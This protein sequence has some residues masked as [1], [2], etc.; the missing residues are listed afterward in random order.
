MSSERLRRLDMAKGIAWFFVGALAMV[1]LFRFTRG[2]GPTTALTDLTPWGFWI[3]FD[4][5]GGVALAAGGFVITATVY[6]FHLENYHAIVRPAVLTA[7]LG[8]IA[9]VIGLLFDLGLPWNIWHMILFWNPHSPLFEVGWCVM[10]YSTV[11]ALEFAPVVLESAKHPVLMKV[12]TFVKKG[13][14]VFVILGIAF[15]TLHQSSLGSLFLIMPHRLDPLWYTPILPILF[16]ISAVG[17]GLSMI[18]TES[19]I[20]SWLYEKKPETHLLAGLAKAASIVL[21]LFVIV[22]FGDLIYR[23]QIGR[24]FT[25]SFNTVLFWIEISMM[26]FIPIIAM[27]IPSIRNRARILRWVAGL[28]VTGIVLNRVDIGGLAMIETTGTRYV[29]AWTEF[30]VSIGIVALAVLVF[31]FVVERFSVMEAGPMCTRAGCGERPKLLGMPRTVA[32]AVIGAGLAAALM[33]TSAID[34]YPVVA[35]PVRAPAFDDQMVIDG[36]RN[37]KGVR[38]DHKMHAEDIV[39]EDQGGCAGCHHMVRMGE[40]VTACDECHRDMEMPTNIF[41][42]ELH[43]DMLRDTDKGCRACHLDTK[44]P[45]ERQ[46]TT[47]CMECHKGMVPEGSSYP[48]KNPPYFGDAPSY[49]DAMHT[50]CKGCHDKMD[51]E[52]EEEVPTLGLCRTCHGEEGIEF[53][54]FNPDRT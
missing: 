49:E 53:D 31:F 20:T 2:L 41:D 1:A 32:M 43:A 33:P 6:I 9:V 51:E 25:Y 21:T 14:I 5:M 10:L 4:V 22:R 8:Y 17:L 37:G 46:Y 12:F 23:D 30:A 48:P 38:F 16:F 42:H 26:G 39:D 34:G 50:M 35:Q 44:L 27:S 3:G 15:S 40:K 47:P 45:K 36:N 7:F 18:M 11:L 19:L 52:N 24:M 29:P 54:P 13:T 28:T